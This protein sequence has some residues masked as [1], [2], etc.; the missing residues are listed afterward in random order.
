MN[1]IKTQRQ[2]A[3]KF[4]IGNLQFFFEVLKSSKISA[5]QDWD[6]HPFVLS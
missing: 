1:A 2:I 3:R 5:E 4:K 6:R